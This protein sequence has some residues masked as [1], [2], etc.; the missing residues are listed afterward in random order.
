MGQKIIPTAL[1][2]GIN[3]QWD[4]QWIAPKNKEALW[5]KES[6]I[7]RRMFNQK[8]PSA[9]IAKIEIHRYGDVINIYIHSSRLGPILGQQGKNLKRITEWAQKALKNRQYKIKIEVI[10]ER[11]AGLNAQ[12]VAQD[13]AKRIVNR[14]NYRLIQQKAIRTGK[15][16]GVHGMKIIISGR[17]NGADIARRSVQAFGALPLSTLKVRM[18]YGFAISKTNYG[19]IGVKVWI[20]KPTTYFLDHNE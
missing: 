10:E 15:R 8:L 18:N 19:Q 17:L 11:N 7:L 14:E 16:L 6:V 4:S 3:Q 9:F 13:I 12:I 20:Y 1:R 5:I 2:I